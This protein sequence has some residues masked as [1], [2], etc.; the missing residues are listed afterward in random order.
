MPSARAAFHAPAY[1]TQSIPFAV[2]VSPIVFSVCGGSGAFAG[3]ARAGSPP[4]AGAMP[5]G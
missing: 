3:S 1:Q 5:L 4:A 2:S